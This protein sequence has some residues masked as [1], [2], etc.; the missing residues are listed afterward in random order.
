[1]SEQ[2]TD[3][4][5][6][7]TAVV[8]DLTRNQTALP[9]AP[10]ENLLEVEEPEDDKASAHA[11]PPQANPS[12]WTAYLPRSHDRPVVAFRLSAF[13]ARAPPES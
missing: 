13:A 7:A 10:E 8:S 6:I 2:V 1:M 12:Q 11:C 4:G 5:G 3:F 9:T